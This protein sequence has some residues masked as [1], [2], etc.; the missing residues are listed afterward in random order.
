MILEAA[1]AARSAPSMAETLL[2][3]ARLT[4][5]SRRARCGRAGGQARGVRRKA[6]L[7]TSEAED[8]LATVS[9][10]AGRIAR[11]PSERRHPSTGAGES[12]A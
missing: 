6:R 12:E 10:D 3:M 2:E 9:E 11:P 4:R 5:C 1:I 8:A 7:D